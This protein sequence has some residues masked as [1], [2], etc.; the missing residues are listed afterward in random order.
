[1]KNAGEVV[2]ASSVCYKQATQECM[3]YLKMET[4]WRL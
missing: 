1:M 3:S 2:V 4:V